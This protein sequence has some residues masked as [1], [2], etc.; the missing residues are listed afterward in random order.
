LMKPFRGSVNIPYLALMSWNARAN[1][2]VKM[3]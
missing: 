1:K 2:Q 3:R